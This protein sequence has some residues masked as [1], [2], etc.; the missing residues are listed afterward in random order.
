MLLKSLIHTVTELFNPIYCLVRI[1]ECVLP[2][3]RFKN[4]RD[5]GKT[6]YERSVYESVVDRSL[7]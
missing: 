7:H 6:F 3:F 2:K 1:N 4:K 5:H